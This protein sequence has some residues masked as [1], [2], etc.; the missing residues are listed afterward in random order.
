MKQKNTF[1]ITR[2]QALVSIASAAGMIPL[3]AL[4][5]CGGSSATSTTTDTNS[6]T[7]TGTDTGTGSSGSGTT[8]DNGSWASGGTNNMTAD[9]PDDSLFEAS[10]TCEIQL[11]GQQTEGPCYFDG[12]YLDDIS[13]GETGLPM[14]LCLQLV[15]QSCNPLANYEIEV[16]HCDVEGIY[17]GDTTGSSDVNGFNSSFCTGND[18]RALASRWFRGI[19]VTDASGRVNFKTCFP[20]WYS[21][22][23]I[24]IHFRVRNNNNDQ[25]VSQF[26]FS[27]DFCDEICTS[28]SDYASRGTPDTHLTSDTVFGNDYADYLFNIEQNEDGSLLAYKRIMIS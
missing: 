26:G 13:E 22:R 1:Q 25:L 27:D 15:D 20:G 24:H 28:H 11:T 23:A 6:G 4:T 2:R 18:S 16:W 7:N 3:V 5:G 10:S 12:D 14:M 17:S 21:S 8:I 9:F 19:Q